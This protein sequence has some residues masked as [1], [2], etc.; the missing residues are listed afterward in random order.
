LHAE[1][2]GQEARA[3]HRCWPVR[4]VR[5]QRRFMIAKTQIDELYSER[6]ALMERIRSSAYPRYSRLVDCD[7]TGATLTRAKYAP[8]RM[9]RGIHGLAVS[10]LTSECSGGERTLTIGLVVRQVKSCVLQR[11]RWQHRYRQGAKPRGQSV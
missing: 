7:V 8:S 4:A 1:R 3:A 11:L 2:G 6:L 10:K 5:K 9:T